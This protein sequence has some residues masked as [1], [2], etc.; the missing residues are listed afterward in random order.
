LK[1]GGGRG[2]VVWAERILIACSHAI[3]DTIV[4]MLLNVS[5]G[6]KVVLI[7]TPQLKIRNKALLFLKESNNAPA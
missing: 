6:T 4:S 7:E 1:D 3:A 2:E 5:S